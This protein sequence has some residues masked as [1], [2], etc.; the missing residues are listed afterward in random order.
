MF[1]RDD[2]R[3]IEPFREML[4]SWYRD[5]QRD[6]PWRKTRDPYAVLVAEVL[7]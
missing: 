1:E 7:L 2:S 5:H 3:V 6:L 4:L